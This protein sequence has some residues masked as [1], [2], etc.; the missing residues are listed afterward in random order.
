MAEVPGPE[1]FQAMLDQALAG[2]TDMAR[3]T[4]SMWKSL[5][6]EGMSEAAATYVVAAWVAAISTNKPA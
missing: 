5:M 3:V 1:K 2:M 6:S 4:V